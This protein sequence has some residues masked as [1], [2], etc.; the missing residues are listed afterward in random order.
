MKKLIFLFAAVVLVTACS[1]PKYAYKFGTHNYSQ[2]L[3]V[4]QPRQVENSV[5]NETL[6][7]SGA[8]ENP[9]VTNEVAV[10]ASVAIDKTTLLKTFSNLSKEDRKELKKELKKEVKTYL[11][12]VKKNDVE[13]IN[14][15]Q[16]MDKDLK[17]AAIF[18]SIGLVL[19]FLG[20]VNSVFWI[21]GVI[22]WIIGII[23]FIKWLARQ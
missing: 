8:N 5:G 9:I 13:S 21:V 4:A 15:T 7:A 18:G 6:V 10:P 17:M 20:G 14:G 12:A 3:A 22:S 23:F 2:K 11:K 1:S 16:A 19:T